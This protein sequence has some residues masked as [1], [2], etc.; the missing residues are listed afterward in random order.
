MSPQYCQGVHITLSIFLI[1]SSIDG[2]GIPPSYTLEFSHHSNRLYKHH[3]EMNQQICLDEALHINFRIFGSCTFWK[4]GVLELPVKKLLL[5]LFNSP[6][7]PKTYDFKVG[8][9]KCLL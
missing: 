1:E 3:T 5:I 7:K 2:I 8:L 6:S 4:K 9:R